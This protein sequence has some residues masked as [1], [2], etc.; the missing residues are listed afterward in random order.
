MFIDDIFGGGAKAFVEAVMRNCKRKEI[1]KLWEF[2]SEK[3]PWMCIRNRKKNI[4]EI[5]V[6]VTQGK[7]TRTSVHKFLGNY[8][9]DKGNLDDQLK[10]MEGKVGGLVSEANK[11]CSQNKLGI[12]EWDGKKIVYKA[13]ITPAVFHNIEAW[14]N[15]RKTDWEKMETLQGKILRGIYGLPKSTPY[16]GLLHELNIIPIKLLITYKRLMVYHNLMNSDDD[17]V[18]KHI[19][20]EQEK[21]GYEECW[22][23]NVKREGEGIGIEV[24]EK[25]VLGKLKSRWKK[26]VKRKVREAF[27]AELKNKKREGRKL[28][29]LGTKGSETYLNEIHNDNARLAVKIRLNMVDWIE[30]NY[31]VA[32]V[33]PLCGEEDSTEHVFSC[34]HG[35]SESGVTVKDLED[36]QKMDKIVD[37]FKKTETCR[38]EKLLE[39]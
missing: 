14:T 2:S 38:T 28:R 20:R 31:G 23:G 9:N 7:L 37:L 30:T 26:Q 19:V 21:S 8:V 5:E 18:A 11:I 39:T 3:S 27:D 33:C 36:G 4:E 22:F 13:Q 24:N 15:L 16:W 6:E 29:F 25:A 34:E 32:G 17:R 12:Y 1:E 10:Y 35:G